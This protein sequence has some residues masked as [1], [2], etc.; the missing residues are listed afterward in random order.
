MHYFL[1]PINVRNAARQRCPLRHKRL[2]Q[3]VCRGP[4]NQGKRSDRSALG[5]CDVARPKRGPCSASTQSCNIPS[6]R[7]L[8]DASTK[9]AHHTSMYHTFVTRALAGGEQGRGAAAVKAQIALAPIVCATCRAAA[10]TASAGER[11]GS[12]REAATMAHQPGSC[13]K[14][15]TIRSIML[16]ASNGYCLA[17]ISADSITASAPSNTARSRAARTSAGRPSHGEIGDVRP[18]F[19]GKGVGSEA[20]RNVRVARKAMGALVSPEGLEPAAPRLK[21]RRADQEFC[22]N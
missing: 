22:R 17:A 5:R 7:G 1:H 13:S 2:D 9:R 10:A 21:V 18:R 19:R 16:T 15:A 4:I 8:E 12:G 3:T 20:A 6:F 11:P 14:R